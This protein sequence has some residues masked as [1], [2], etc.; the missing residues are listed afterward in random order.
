MTA[1]IQVW[2]DG[3]TVC[4]R[5]FEELAH[6]LVTEKPSLSSLRARLLLCSS[7][8]HAVD[9][10][11]ARLFLG[12][13]L[14]PESWLE[15][16]QL[17]EHACNAAG[18]VFVVPTLHAASKLIGGCIRRDSM[19]KTGHIEV[20]VHRSVPENILDSVI[21]APV[22]TVQQPV[23]IPTGAYEASLIVSD[24][25]AVVSTPDSALSLPGLPLR[26]C[27]DV[28]AFIQSTISA[29][30][31]GM[32]ALIDQT[33]L[34]C[35]YTRDA[36]KFEL[37]PPSQMTVSLQAQAF[38]RVS[39][40]AEDTASPRAHSTVPA[41]NRSV[42]TEVPAAAA[43][44]VPAEDDLGMTLSGT[45]YSCACLLCGDRISNP[46]AVIYGLLKAIIL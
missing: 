3:L 31:L 26:W 30:Q 24:V 13:H 42:S 18:A 10:I 45:A 37:V 35:A 44:N 41:Y 23:F 25:A 11:L 1:P 21:I 12:A 43:L 40:P 14:D 7:F 36:A 27:E 34:D 38:L 4:R 20:T 16:A 8:M 28:A 32:H 22:A 2:Y 17:C 19:L 29:T 6:Q 15:A 5:H 33:Q 39:E 46:F 9:R